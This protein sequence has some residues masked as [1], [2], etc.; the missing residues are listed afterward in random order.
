MRAR[1]PIE[2]TASR[3]LV[4]CL[5]CDRPVA[6]VA[7]IGDPEVLGLQ[8]HLFACRPD[9]IRSGVPGL[10]ETLRHFRVR[11]TEPGPQSPDLT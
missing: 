9:R 1:R 5:Y 2:M 6:V 10:A 3:F 7:R 8:N 4:S 11:R